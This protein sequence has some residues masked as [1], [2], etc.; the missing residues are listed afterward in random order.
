MKNMD[1]THPATRVVPPAGMYL[2]P[3][4]NQYHSPTPG[5]ITI[6]ATTSYALTN[7]FGPCD[8]ITS[9]GKGVLVSMP[10]NR[11]TDYIVIVNHDPV[12][13]QQVDIRFNKYCKLE[14]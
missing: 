4:N 5:Q 1:P 13:S 3:V 14:S 8:S 10:N 12:N 11:G 9:H 7:D 2:T 6:V